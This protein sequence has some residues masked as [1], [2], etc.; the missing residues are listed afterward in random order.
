MPAVLGFGNQ[1]WRLASLMPAWAAGRVAPV[2]YGIRMYL[3]E[4][5]A[6]VSNPAWKEGEEEQT[7]QGVW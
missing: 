7:G 1:G 6:S 2:P 4:S 5:L 3:G